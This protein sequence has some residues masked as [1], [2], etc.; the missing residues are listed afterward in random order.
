MNSAW[1]GGTIQRFYSA[2]EQR[3]YSQAYD[4]LSD[5]IEALRKKANRLHAG[6]E[7]DEL[8]HRIE[9]DEV[10]LRVIEW[11]TSPGR[12]SPPSDLIPVKRHR[13]RRK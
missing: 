2:L 9:Q 8:L 3:N 4:L 7:R 12:L 5:K 10:A 13:L 11:V 6:A 1:P